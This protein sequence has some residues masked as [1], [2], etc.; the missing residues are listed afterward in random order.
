[1]SIAI[2]A[3]GVAG[4]DPT[5]P[6][7]VNNK[8]LKPVVKVSEK[9]KK[10]AVKIKKPRGWRLRSTLFSDDRRTAVINNKVLMI[11]EKVN[12][13]TLVDIQPGRVQIRV[14][15]KIRTLRLVSKD[16][17]TNMRQVIRKKIT[18]EPTRKNGL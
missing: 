2:S 3:S 16:V 8:I 13:A 10:P 17:K 14:K 11:G 12:G 15:G 6:P 9:T 5:K 1:M 18:H 7:M 4:V